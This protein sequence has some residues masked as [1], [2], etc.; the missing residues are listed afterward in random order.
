MANANTAYFKALNSIG[1]KSPNR[2]PSP[3]PAMELSSC[4][5]SFSSPR[6]NLGMLE[7]SPTS[8]KSSHEPKAKRSTSGLEQEMHGEA[9][10]LRNR[11]RKERVFHQD[12]D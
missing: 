6:K 11:S 4:S 1:L 12:I 9:S 8:S 2:S 3:T 10:D 7:I 5:S